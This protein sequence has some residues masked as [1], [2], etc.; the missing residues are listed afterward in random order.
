MLFYE[1]IPEG[2]SSVDEP[3]RSPGFDEVDTEQSKVKIEL[4]KELNE[5]IW[6]DNMQFLQV[7]HSNQSSHAKQTLRI[8]HQVSSI[9]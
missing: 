6:Q 3:L 5:W 4:S 7:R 1:R 8:M 2:R 9:A